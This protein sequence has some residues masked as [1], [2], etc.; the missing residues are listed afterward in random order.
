LPA[1]VQRSD[2]DQR[3]VRVFVGAREPESEVDTV[4]SR[5]ARFEHGEDGRMRRLLVHAVVVVG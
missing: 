2:H 5:G 1:A 4:S 3:D